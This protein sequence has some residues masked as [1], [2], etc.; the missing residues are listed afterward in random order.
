MLLLRTALILLAAAICAEAY[1]NVSSSIN[2]T[3]EVPYI[4]EYFYAG[5]RYVPYETG[6]HVFEDQIYVERL[7]PIGG[8]TRQTPLVLIHGNA[9]TGTVNVNHAPVETAF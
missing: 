8:A 4:R 3:T 1:K 9:Q 2:F 5:G 6:G 7:N